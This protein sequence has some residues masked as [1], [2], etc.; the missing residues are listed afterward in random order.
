MLFSREFSIE[1][2]RHHG[3]DWYDVICITTWKNGAVTHRILGS[4]DRKGTAEGR[5]QRIEKALG[6]DNGD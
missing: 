3:L 2:A 6:R 5:K 1:K 4:Y